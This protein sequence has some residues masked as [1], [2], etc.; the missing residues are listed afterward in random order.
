LNF[1][2][3]GAGV[4]SLVFSN[5]LFLNSLFNDLSPQVQN[6]S[7]TAVAVIPEPS[8]AALLLAGLAGFA[9]WRRLRSPGA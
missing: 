1:N 2:V 8:S 7:V 3:I 4:S 6:G 9:A 5:S